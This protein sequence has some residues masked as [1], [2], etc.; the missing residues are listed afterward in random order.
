MAMCGL[1]SARNNTKLSSALLS[2]GRVMRRWLVSANVGSAAGDSPYLGPVEL[3]LLVRHRLH[4]P[5]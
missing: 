2:V 5:A 3:D 1:S 4:A